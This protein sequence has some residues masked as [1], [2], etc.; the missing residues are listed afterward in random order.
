MQYFLFLLRKPDWFGWETETFKSLELK[1]LN[2]LYMRFES[3]GKYSFRSKILASYGFKTSDI[4]CMIR[5]NYFN[6]VFSFLRKG[7]A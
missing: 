2:M 6:G 1:I 3:Y 5:I 7:A 4:M